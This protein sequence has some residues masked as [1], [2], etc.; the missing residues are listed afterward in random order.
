M[1]AGETNRTTWEGLASEARGR[2]RRRRSRRARGAGSRRAQSRA[3]FARAAGGRSPATAAFGGL[4]RASRRENRASRPSKRRKTR[5]RTRVDPR[6]RARARRNGGGT[7]RASRRGAHLVHGDDLERHACQR[8]RGKRASAAAATGF[9]SRRAASAIRNLEWS[10]YSLLAD[11]RCEPRELTQVSE[12]RRPTYSIPI[13]KT[14]SAHG[15]RA[16]RAQPPPSRTPHVTRRSR[17]HPRVLPLPPSPAA[18]RRLPARAAR[19][20]RSVRVVRPVRLR[21]PS[22]RKKAGHRG[23]RR[24]RPTSSTDA[25]SSPPRS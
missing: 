8:G 3:R 14:A 17:R 23:A 20:S 2:R 1:R 15:S 24:R 25:A 6:S 19:L 4:R 10:P 12:S 7:R 21:L 18:R 9:C 22:R 13:S 5:E 11:E 16:S